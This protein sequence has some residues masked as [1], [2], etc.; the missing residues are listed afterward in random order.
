MREK[1]HPNTCQMDVE[2]SA[3]FT[4]CIAFQNDIVY[5]CQ[6]HSVLPFS[7][8]SLSSSFQSNFLHSAPLQHHYKIS[9]GQEKC[10]LISRNISR[11]ALN[12]RVVVLSKQNLCL[13][14]TLSHPFLLHIIDP[15]FSF[16]TLWFRFNVR[17]MIIG[18]CICKCLNISY[19]KMCVCLILSTRAR[20]NI[21]FGTKQ[22]NDHRQKS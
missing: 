12:I 19:I 22:I 7:F 8:D 20:L 6:I 14:L 9:S 11:S 17:V 10:I 13:I 1:K 3:L 21:Y 16:L 15:M 4:H 2:V 18:V 5:I